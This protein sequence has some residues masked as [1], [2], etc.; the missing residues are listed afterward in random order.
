MPPMPT[1]PP[2]LPSIDARLPEM[3][4]MLRRWSEINS[5]TTNLAGLAA[6]AA[7]LEAAFASL[8]GDMLRVA[9]P[10]AQSINSRGETVESPL[11]QAIVIRKRSDAPLRVLLVIHYDTVYAANDSFQRVEQ[12]DAD[13]FRGPG[14]VDAKGGI[15]VMLEALRA[16]ESSPEAGRIGWK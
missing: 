9:L 16:F 11:G 6:M 15:L 8:G 3:A 12:V 14:V 7:E 2:S 4:A 5:G 13:T 10:P 1:P